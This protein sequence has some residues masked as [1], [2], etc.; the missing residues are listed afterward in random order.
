MDYQKAKDLRS[1][2]FSDLMTDKLTAGKG[3]GFSLR[4]TLSEKTKA[5]M[6]GIKEKF[7][8]MNIVKTMTFGSKLGPALYGKMMGRSKEDMKYFTDKKTRGPGKNKTPGQMDS[9]AD[10][11]AVDA[12]GLIY[13]LMLRN[14]EDEKLRK[15][16]EK[17]SIEEKDSE[18]ELRNQE[19][20]KAL[21]GRRKEKVK[22]KPYRDEKGRFAKRPTKE[23][24]KPEPKKEPFRDEKGRFA[25][26]P[27]AEKVS[28]EKIP[29]PTTP[30]VK[31]STAVKIGT[32]AAIVGAGVGVGGLLMPS[33]TVATEIDKASKLVGVDRALM[34]AMAKQ[35]SGFDPAAG[36]KTSS[37]KGL[38]QFIKGTWKGM[39]D[40]YGS[41]YPILRE[42]GP[43]DAE[44][45]AIAGA[46]F[47]KENSD[48]LSKNNIPVNATTIYA[49]HFLGPG[50]AKTLL[51]ADPNKSAA[52]I[53]PKAAAANDFIFYEKTGNKPDIN[54]PRTVQQVVDV[55]FQKVGQYQQK[56]AEA[57]NIPSTGSQIDQSSKENT[58]LKELLNKDKPKQSTVN[59]TT[60]SAENKETKQSSET[61]DDRPAHLKKKG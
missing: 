43:E 6:T 16:E 51:T 19:L 14:Q 12:L 8:P 39:V 46:L 38:Y 58:D 22:E 33:Q 17:G 27:T 20:V 50:G 32:G 45:N 21:T 26:K 47:I 36:A 55:L 25:K 31:P 2:S 57:L 23:E 59:N 61:V 48:Y 5:K 30:S 44:A 10:S 11:M 1:K 49:A 54:K 37:A 18:E 3:I 7:D 53:M 34:Y 60:V 41:K 40:K 24:P 52:E 15:E 28:T 4:E 35:E 42:R 9:Q 56:Y 29:T 13:R